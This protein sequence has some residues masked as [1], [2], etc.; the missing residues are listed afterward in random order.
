[1]LRFKNF[2]LASN[3]EV[4]KRWRELLD[5]MKKDIYFM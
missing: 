1:M 5:K 4:S 3:G 2:I